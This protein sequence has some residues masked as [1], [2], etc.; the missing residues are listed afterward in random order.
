MFASTEKKTNLDIKNFIFIEW[1]PQ[2][3]FLA[4][5]INT[6]SSDHFMDPTVGTWTILTQCIVLKLEK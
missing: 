1:E 3:I 6:C 5:T 4:I 2:S